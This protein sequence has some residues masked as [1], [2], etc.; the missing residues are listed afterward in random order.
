MQSDLCIFYFFHLLWK[1]YGVSIIPYA[2][3]KIR[4]NPVSVLISIFEP[5]TFLLTSVHGPRI[6]T[7]ICVHMGAGKMSLAHI[8][9]SLAL[10]FYC[11]DKNEFEDLIRYVCMYSAHYIFYVY[12]YVYVYIYKY[13]RMYAYIYIFV[14]LYLYLYIYLCTYTYIHTY[15]YT[16]IYIYIHM[17]MYIYIFIQYIYI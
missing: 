12:E 9:P 6:D 11:D 10:G 1:R 14:Y 15:I 8:D 3:A 2:A 17:Y 4:E 13:I 5:S 7:S 16:Y